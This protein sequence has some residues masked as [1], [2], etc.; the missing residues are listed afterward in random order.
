MPCGNALLLAVPV[1]ELVS[2]AAEHASAGRGPGR[3]TSGLRT[4]GED[5]GGPIVTVANDGRGFERPRPDGPGP[6]FVE[7]PVQRACATLSRDGDENALW[8]TA[9]SAEQKLKDMDF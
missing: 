6:G 1:N 2:N 8:H 7:D 9:L 5:G 3:I 4:A